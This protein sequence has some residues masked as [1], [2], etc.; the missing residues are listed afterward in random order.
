M[1]APFEKKSILVLGCGAVGLNTALRLQKDFPNARVTIMAEDLV[2]SGAAGIFRPTSSIRGPNAETTSM[3]TREAW[4][5]YN[6]LKKSEPQSLTGIVDVIFFSFIAGR[7]L[8][9]FLVIITRRYP[10]IC[11]PLNQ[12][13]FPM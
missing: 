10:H 2:S 11:S 13:P 8:I 7:I 9:L 6:D 1:A 12:F 3:W 5:F 4:H